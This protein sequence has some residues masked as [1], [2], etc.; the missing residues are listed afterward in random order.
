MKKRK[1][2]NFRDLHCLRDDDG[3]RLKKGRIFRSGVL[4][5][6]APRALRKIGQLGLDEVTD[7]RSPE[8]I[9]LKPD[10]PLPCASV[11]APFGDPEFT[12]A[13]D[14]IDRYAIATFWKNRACG[15]DFA[16]HEREFYR[17][18]Y[19]KNLCRNEGIR[20]LFRLM[21]EQKTFLFHCHGGKDRTGVCA[22]LLLWALGFSR[23]AIVRDYL[24]TNKP[25]A[26][27]ASRIGLRLL[28]FNRNGIDA[29]L[30]NSFAMPE[31]L[32]AMFC[33]IEARWGSVEA[34]LLAEYGVTADELAACK[35]YY[36]E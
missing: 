27:A 14:G 1:L 34:F 17:N 36:L 26:L 32:D 31:L 5:G 9:R 16:A 4:A 35:A 13:P 20:E 2:R 7:L 28:G 30:C 22:A 12:Q 10:D 3:P 18:I 23:E 24:K 15:P 19:S 29:V 33:E 6:L 8:E 25:A 11:N 21:T